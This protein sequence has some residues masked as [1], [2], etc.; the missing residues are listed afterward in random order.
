MEV[1]TVAEL[2]HYRC[3]APGRLSMG[4]VVEVKQVG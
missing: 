1:G 3:S 4:G 2:M